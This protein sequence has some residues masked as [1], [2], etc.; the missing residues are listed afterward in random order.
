[1]RG[2]TKVKQVAWLLRQA[3]NHDAHN[4]P[5]SARACRREAAALEAELTRDAQCRECG[6][7]LKDP[8][9]VELGIGPECRTKK[10]SS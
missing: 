6:R 9:S 8:T 4:R 1:M 3:D 10:G 7:A 2:P 5:A